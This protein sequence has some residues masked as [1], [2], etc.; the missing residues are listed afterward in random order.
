MLK[1]PSR[2]NASS[3]QIILHIHVT[4]SPKQD[5]LSKSSLA[6]QLVFT[7]VDAHDEAIPVAEQATLKLEESFKPDIPI[8][9]CRPKVSWCSSISWKTVILILMTLKTID[10]SHLWSDNYP[11]MWHEFIHWKGFSLSVENCCAYLWANFFETRSW[12]SRLSTWFWLSLWD[13]W[14]LIHQYH[15]YDS[16][17][18]S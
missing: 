2:T 6:H 3:V 4:R 1:Y 17:P 11:K 10:W 7:S 16:N 5:D 8:F 9:L 15:Y 18:W 14:A 12:N 13:V